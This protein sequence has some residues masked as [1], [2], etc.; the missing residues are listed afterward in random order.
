MNSA[1]YNVI[2]NMISWR[3]S[4]RDGHHLMK[5][6]SK[7]M[8]VIFWCEQA[9][10]WIF[11]V[12]L[13]IQMAVRESWSQG[14]SGETCLPVFLGDLLDCVFLTTSI[15]TIRSCSWDTEWAQKPDEWGCS[16]AHTALGLS[17]GSHDNDAGWLVFITK[18]SSSYFILPGLIWAPVPLHIRFCS[19]Y[20]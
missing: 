12:V 13:N 15:L 14:S 8:M 7:M 10:T 3:W 18:F 17:S 4:P 20:N 5:M 1:N 11:A 6:K 16:Q 2:I 9:S 19:K